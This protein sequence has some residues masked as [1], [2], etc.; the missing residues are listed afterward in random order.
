M[1][2]HPDHI[3][4]DVETVD[5][6]AQITL[7]A[8]QELHP[9]VEVSHDGLTWQAPTRRMVLPENV[10]TP[11]PKQILDFKYFRLRLATGIPALVSITVVKTAATA[12]LDVTKDLRI[13]DVIR[14]R[15]TEIERD[16]AGDITKVTRTGG[17]EINVTRDEGGHLESWADEENTWTVERNESDDITGVTVE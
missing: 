15:P 2:I 13:P 1:K 9:V 12:G 6:S 11:V 4:S 7:S 17:R 16:E 10:A 8:N 14:T 3:R 5:D